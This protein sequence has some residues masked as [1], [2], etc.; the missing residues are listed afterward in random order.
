MTIAAVCA[1]K[2]GDGRELNGGPVYEGR[3][4]LCYLKI[5]LPSSVSLRRYFN[6]TSTL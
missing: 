6:S 3:E 4:L 1:E 5:Q 2:K